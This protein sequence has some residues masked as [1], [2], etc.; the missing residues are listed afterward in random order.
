M[1]LGITVSIALVNFVLIAIID[2]CSQ[3]EMYSTAVFPARNV[4]SGRSKHKQNYMLQSTAIRRQGGLLS[5]S[6]PTE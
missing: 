2:Q 4:R 1:F 3:L 5:L 6:C